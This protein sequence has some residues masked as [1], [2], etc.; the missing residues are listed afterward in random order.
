[1][2]SKLC[3]N[4][5]IQYLSKEDLYQVGFI[6]QYQVCQLIQCQFRHSSTINKR[7]TSTKFTKFYSFRYIC[8]YYFLELDIRLSLC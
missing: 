8:C 4:Q 6:G 5:V 3:E 2:T 7:K 1:M